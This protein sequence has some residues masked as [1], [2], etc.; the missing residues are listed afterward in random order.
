MKGLDPECGKEAESSKNL[1]SVFI[2]T[3]Y[4]QNY[5]KIF[6]YSSDYKMRILGKRKSAGLRG[7]L[8]SK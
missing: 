8:Q 5:F 3:P 7:C 4:A 6:L 1:S 2:N